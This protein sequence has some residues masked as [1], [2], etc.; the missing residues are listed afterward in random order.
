MP[1]ISE[2]QNLWGEI[3]DWEN[4]GE[5][6]SGFFGD[7]SLQWSISLFPRIKN[8]IKKDAHILEIAPGFGRWTNYLKDYCNKISIVD[9]NSNCIEHCKEK[10]AEES[11]FE[12]FVNDGK[13]LDMIEDNSI[14]FVFSYDSL[15]HVNQEVIENYLTQL[16]KKLKDGGFCF[17][18]HSNLAMYKQQSNQCVDYSYLAWRDEA[19]DACFVRE[20]CQKNNLHCLTQELVNWSGNFYNDCYS[21]IQKKNNCL[22]NTLTRVFYNDVSFEQA[23]AQKMSSYYNFDENKPSHNKSSLEIQKNI[24]ALSKRFAGKKICFFGAGAFAKSTLPRLDLSIISPICFFDS[25]ENK[26][27]FE[28]ASIPIRHVSEIQSVSPD[29]VIMTVS[30][31]KVSLKELKAQIKKAN[32]N[33]KL[34]DI[35]RIEDEL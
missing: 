1:T 19:V 31:P 2:N 21:V 28:I 12:Y 22:N 20:I 23:Y 17:L 15:V 29:I 13:S 24:E 33:I 10:F 11:H 7:S 6:W 32:L 26:T 9:L 35:Q 25:D 34:I 5:E 30:V 3:Y 16:S 4:K 18:H 14:D 27:G 8:F